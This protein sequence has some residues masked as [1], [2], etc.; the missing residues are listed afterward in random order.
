M[1][2]TGRVAVVTGAGSGIGRAT[3]VRFAAEGAV[4]AVADMDE[5]GG[6]ATVE[7][8]QAAGGRG[9]YV[10]TDVTRL[11]DVRAAFA[12]AVRTGGSGRLDI[13]FN[14]AGIGFVGAVD[15]TS[16]EDWERVMAVNLRGVYHGCLCAVEQMKAQG[17]GGVILNM[18][19]AIAT[20]GLGRRAAY[21]ASK[22]AVLA[23]TRSMQ[24]DCAPHGIRVNALMPGTILTP[25]VEG[26]LKRAYAGREQEAL[27]SIR[28]RQLTGE[29][30]GPDDVA[31][32][33][34]FLASDDARFIMGAGLAVDG[35][36]T[37]GKA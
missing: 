3:A 15:E 19:S 28:G 23:L 6:R 18:S 29:L 14:N 9:E 32:A 27:A 35:G 12:Q 33:A 1:R 26:Y 13:V 21:A 25:F 4:V 16:P 17:G 22:G 20:T 7:A 36:L 2:L 11:A 5:A 30:G 24:V 8:I 34:L 37:A 31:A 10:A